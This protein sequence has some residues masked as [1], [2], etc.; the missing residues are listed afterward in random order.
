MC[1]EALMFENPVSRPAVRSSG[2]WCDYFRSNLR[3]LLDL[4]WQRGPELTAQEIE[5][6]GPSL[7]EFRLAESSEG[8]HLKYLAAKYACVTGDSDYETDIAL[9]VKEEQRHSR[10]LAEFLR[11]AGLQL[12]TSTKLDGIFRR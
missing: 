11:I 9:F 4:P 7:Q 12:A 10:L 5:T 3:R 6:L 2:E 1:K 8:N